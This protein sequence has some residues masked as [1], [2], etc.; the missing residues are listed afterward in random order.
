MAIVYPGDYHHAKMEAIPSWKA[1]SLVSFLRRRQSRRLACTLM[2][3]RHGNWALPLIAVTLHAIGLAAN[4]P[5]VGL[6]RGSPKL[7]ALTG[8]IVEHKG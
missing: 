8:S 1:I 6:A 3:F 7:H 4:P 2:S 5:C